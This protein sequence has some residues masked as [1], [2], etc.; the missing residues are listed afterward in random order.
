MLAE[1]VKA[2]A[3]IAHRIKLV[4]VEDHLPRR[5]GSQANFSAGQL[6]KSCEDR[7]AVPESVSDGTPALVLCEIARRY[8]H[9]V[10]GRI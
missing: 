9:I 3:P 5:N 7:L 8:C 4:V 10:I 1:T 6:E 2:E